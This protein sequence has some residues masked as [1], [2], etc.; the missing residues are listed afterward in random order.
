MTN[1]STGTNSG[2][3]GS[4]GIE[5]QKHCALYFLFEK[6]ATIKDRKYFIC[7]EHHDDFLFCYLTQA[8]VITSIDA[9]QAKKSSSQWGMGDALSLILKKITQ[10]GLD[11]SADTHPKD[12]IYTHS[13]N[14]VT[15]DAISLH[16]GS[17]PVNKRKTLLINES[18]HEVRY[19]D[20]DNDIR[21]KILKDLKK[22]SV[23]DVNQLS[24][25]DKLALMYID[26]PKKARGQKDTLIG[27]FKRIFG[28]QVNDP[29]AAV[30]AL[31][32]LFRNVENV[33]NTGNIAKLMDTSK[34]VESI[35][36]TQAMHI[37]T[38]RAK[39]YELWRKKGDDLANRLSISVFE[40]D[41]FQLQFQNSLDLF[42]DLKQTEHRKLYSYVESNKTRWISHTDDI[43][44][45]NDIYSSFIAENSTNLSHFDIKAAICAA[46]VEIKG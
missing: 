3:H 42:K 11:L 12:A 20:I 32:L 35:A 4:T 41:R 10:V 15:N 31:L 6:Y 45:I 5:F 44:C 37:I 21:I 30:D 13:L 34:R 26:L 22:V 33:L 29:V 7:L 14:F 28:A 9:Y 16:C 25:L 24:E 43:D 36:I 23:I 38:T 17:L 2:V 18:N 39:A 19:V 1:S 46:Y 40:Q 27:Q 8:D